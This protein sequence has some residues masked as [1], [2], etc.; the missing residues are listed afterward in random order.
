M[1]WNWC[2]RPFGEINENPLNAVREHLARITGV[3]NLMLLKEVELGHKQEVQPTEATQ[4][5]QSPSEPRVN[6]WGEFWR[7]LWKAVGGWFATISTCIVLL[8]IWDSYRPK[9]SITPGGTQNPKSPFGTYFIVQNH[10][11]LP[12]SNIRYL[13]RLTV[14]TN[15]PPTE[16]NQIVLPEQNVSVIPQMKS[17][18]SYSLSIHY[19]AVQIGAI[20]QGATNQA[21]A[22]NQIKIQ[23]SALFLSFDVSYEPKFFGKR[24]DTLY[25]VAMMDVDGN[26]QWLP[27]AH[28]SIFAQTIDTNLIPRIQSIPVTAAIPTN[29]GAQVHTDHPKPN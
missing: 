28:Q 25:F 15:F 18:E 11:A 5:T 1:F 14:M 9:I 12:I 3:A 13:S 20:G 16:S 21:A 2:G 8:A 26:W 10:G 4:S 22:T 17:L 19:Q 27:S 24:T 6:R 7:Y 29:S 23:M